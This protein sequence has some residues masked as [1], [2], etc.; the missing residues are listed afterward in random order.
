MAEG[1][2]RIKYRAATTFKWD[3]PT[4]VC[5]CGSTRFGK[6]FDAANL[7]ETLAGRIVLSVGSYLRSDDELGLTPTQK[8]YLDILHFRKIDICDEILVIDVDKYVGESTSR[9]I[10]YAESLGKKIR[11]LSKEM[12]DLAGEKGG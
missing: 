2:N 11:Y 1:S 12:A 8:V 9:E 4:V 7:A 10:A 6:E 5:L 3:R